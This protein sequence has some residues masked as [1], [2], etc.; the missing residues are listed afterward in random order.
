MRF[1][2]TGLNSCSTPSS[3]SELPFAPRPT[4]H[5][6]LPSGR[7]QSPRYTLCKPA[8]EWRIDSPSIR[9]GSNAC[10]ERRC[11]RTAPRSA[12]EWPSGLLPGCPT[13][14]V[15]AQ[16]I[17]W[18]AQGMPRS[19]QFLKRRMIKRLEQHQRHFLRQTHWCSPSIPAR[20]N[21]RTAE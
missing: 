14:V 9:I 17:V 1:A 15:W 13:S 18:R 10:T 19:T 21:H 5:M 11:K 3:A 4:R 16:F 7:R 12:N 8:R 6:Q 2:S 20:S